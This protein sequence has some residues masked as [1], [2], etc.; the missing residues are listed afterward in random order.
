[1]SSSR[2]PGF[3][4]T[5]DDALSH[6]L[7]HT[8]LTLPLSEGLSLE[9]GKET[10][11]LGVPTSCSLKSLFLCSTSCRSPYP[12]SALWVPRPGMTV[13]L[14]PKMLSVV[15]DDRRWKEADLERVLRPRG[16]TQT[17]HCPSLQSRQH[18]AETEHWDMPPW[19]PCTCLAAFLP[20]TMTV[21]SE[22][23]SV[24]PPRCLWAVTTNSA[25][26]PYMGHC[27]VK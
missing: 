10:K 5:T 6:T 27:W 2:C 21:A 17:S 12:R 11:M 22:R 15:S 4:T 20:A 24:L 3:S 25:R 9:M 23:G 19:V 8:L 7:K 13:A 1:M 16:A 14:L 18:K 26:P